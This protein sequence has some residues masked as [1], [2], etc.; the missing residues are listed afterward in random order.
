MSSGNRLRCREGLVFGIGLTGLE[1]GVTYAQGE[2]SVV[3]DRSSWPAMCA[4]T[5]GG[6]VRRIGQKRT[7]ESGGDDLQR[8]TE[9]VGRPQV[10]DRAADTR[11]VPL[12]VRGEQLSG[13][14]SNQVQETDDAGALS[15]PRAQRDHC[16]EHRR[17]NLPGQPRRLC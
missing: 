7:Q 11:P 15:K 14:A 9:A 5:P 12:K 2:R 17:S 3:A 1:A 8:Q 16:L 10:R 6:H 13:T 4:M